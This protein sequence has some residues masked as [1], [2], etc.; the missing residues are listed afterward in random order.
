LHKTKNIDTSAI[1]AVFCMD[2]SVRA[3]FRCEG[4]SHPC[5]ELVFSDG[6]SGELHQGRSVTPYEDGSILVYQPAEKHWIENRVAGHHI[7]I[8][9]LGGAAEQLPPGGYNGTPT[10]R[11]RF[12]EI[13][14]AHSAITPFGDRRC[15]LLAEL[16]VYDLLELEGRKQPTVRLGKAEQIRQYIDANLDMALKTD[17]LAGMACVSRDY[18]RQLFREGVGQ[19]LRSYINHRRMERAAYLLQS[20]SDPVGVIGRSVSIA[21]EFYFSR[22]FKKTHGCSPTAFRKRGTSQ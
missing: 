10:I 14:H 1:H 15:S 13:R 18:L 5:T 9:V 2:V 3:G 16:L 7:C 4:H 12:L 11:E 22:L 6:S 8:G 21:N 17:D 19:S 20:T